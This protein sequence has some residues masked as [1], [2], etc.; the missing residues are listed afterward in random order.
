MPRYRSSRRRAYKPITSYRGQSMFLRVLSD[1]QFNALQ[2]LASQTSDPH[3]HPGAFQDIATADRISLIHALHGE[4]QARQ[5]NE[6][7]GGSLGDA[8]ASLGNGIYD[9]LLKPVYD[10]VLKPIWNEEKQALYEEMPELQALEDAWNEVSNISQMVS[11]DNQISDHTRLV[12]GFVGES[13]K[14]AED[15][16][17]SVRGYTRDTTF[18]ENKFI[19]V[20]VDP[21]TNHVIVACRGSASPEDYLVDDYKILTDGHPRDLISSDL[22]RIVEKYDDGNS[23]EVAGH[24]L[25]ASL[26]AQAMKNNPSFEQSFD[27]VDL[28]NP[29]TS[30]LAEDNVVNDLVSDNSTFFY[31]NVADPVSWATTFGTQ[32][33]KGHLVMNTPQGLN[34]LDNHSIDQ[35]F[36]Q[37]PSTFS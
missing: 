15:Q 31:L 9:H 27:R 37:D 7:V 5:R 17:D 22:R 30:V 3:V 32:I 10:D 34:P 19:S 13:Y 24:S 1:S 35:W 18:D 16:E 25:G 4:E 26:I 8:F 12:A 23:I 20:Y 28:F 2:Q 36:K 29:G 21:T 11:H 6:D 33:P 14:A